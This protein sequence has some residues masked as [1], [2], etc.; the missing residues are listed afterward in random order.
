MG[1][2]LLDITGHRFG[3]LVA[4]VCLGMVDGIR[5]WFCEYDCGT[6]DV[7]VKQNHYARAVRAFCRWM[8]KG[9]R[10]PWNPLESIGLVN[11]SADR[12]HDRRE[13]SGAELEQ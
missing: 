13:L 9:K 12:R 6:R 1:R 5:F 3:R 4:R 11:T 2:K 10:L 8:V 7:V